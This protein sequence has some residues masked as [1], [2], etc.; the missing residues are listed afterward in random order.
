VINT[1]LILTTIGSNIIGTIVGGLAIYAFLVRPYQR[2]LEQQDL[3]LKDSEK[4]LAELQTARVV[5][6]LQ[7]YRD[8]QKEQES[9]LQNL[10][11]GG[12]AQTLEIFKKFLTKDEFE[13]RANERDLQM[14]MVNGK[15]DAFLEFRGELRALVTSHKE[16]ISELFRRVNHVESRHDH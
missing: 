8:Q 12:N 1:W 4:Q 3:A 10:E 13:R 11:A 5:E 2:R 7:K 16:Q 9:R 14:N 6:R 15:L